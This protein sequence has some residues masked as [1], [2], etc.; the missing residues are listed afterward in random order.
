MRIHFRESP[1]DK[2]HP[3]RIVPERTQITASRHTGEGLSNPALLV[4]APTHSAQ[5]ISRATLGKM[6]TLSKNSKLARN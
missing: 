1:V 3:N 4:R 2:T 6:R 5:P